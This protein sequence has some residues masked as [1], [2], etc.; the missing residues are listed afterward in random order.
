MCLNVYVSMC[1]SL[2]YYVCSQAQSVSISLM[3]EVKRRGFLQVDI[4]IG[5]LL[6]AVL[7]MILEILFLLAAKN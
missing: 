7:Q 6:L 5:L 3:K 1:M 4:M 2:L